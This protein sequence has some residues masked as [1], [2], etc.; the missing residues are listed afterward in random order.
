LKAANANTDGIY[1]Q[2]Y[3]G[4]FDI[5][6]NTW[7][8]SLND[9]DGQWQDFKKLQNIKRVI[10]FGGWAYS[11]EPATYNI[12]RMAIINNRET[13]AAN[14]AKFVADE[15]I[16]GVDIDREYPGVRYLSIFTLISAQS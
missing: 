12:L 2:I 10:S 5:D 7:K 6:P 1:T 9:S 13:F 3:W 14:I 16:D 15:G 4:F 8:P 11:T